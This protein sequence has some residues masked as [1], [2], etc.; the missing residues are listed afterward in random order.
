MSQAEF[1]NRVAEEIKITNDQVAAET[2]R[3]KDG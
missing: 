2:I 1:N 3:L